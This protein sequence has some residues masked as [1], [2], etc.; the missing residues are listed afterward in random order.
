[1]RDLRQATAGG[2]SVPA[3][4]LSRSD[5]S[6]P[7]AGPEAAEPIAAVVPVQRGSTPGSGAAAPVRTRF[8]RTPHRGRSSKCNCAALSSH[9]RRPVAI[10]PVARAP[11]AAREG[12]AGRGCR[13]PSAGREAPAPAEGLPRAGPGGDD[14]FFEPPVSPNRR[15]RHVGIDTG[16]GRHRLSMPATRLS[17]IPLEWGAGRGY[18][19]PATGRRSPLEDGPAG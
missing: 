15:R 17:R 7:V 10:V 14:G 19:A 3:L 16:E 11:G 8:R 1:M 9:R 4:S 13:G 12:G 2:P 18:S 6:R 5:R